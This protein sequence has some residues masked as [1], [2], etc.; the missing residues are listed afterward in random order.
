MLAGPSHVV[1]DSAW[2]IVAP[3]ESPRS[4]TH[5]SMILGQTGALGFAGVGGGEAG[6]SAFFSSFSST[7]SAIRYLALNRGAGAFPLAPLIVG[8]AGRGRL[9]LPTLGFGDR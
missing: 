4:P 5:P 3:H 8:V 2:A 7:L 1:S 9:E 6:C